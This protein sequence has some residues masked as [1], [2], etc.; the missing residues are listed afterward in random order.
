MHKL[1][2]AGLD[3]ISCRLGIGNNMFL[4]NAEYLQSGEM[5]MLQLA[6]PPKSLTLLFMNF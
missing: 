4:M 1:R 5:K 6:Q 3:L 2:N